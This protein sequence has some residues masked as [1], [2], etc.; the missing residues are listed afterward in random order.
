MA[1]VRI[2]NFSAGLWD[3]GG[4]E[5]SPTDS[6]GNPISLRIAEGMNAVKTTTLRS[7]GGS[8]LIRAATNVH[9]LVRFGGMRYAGVGT[10]FINVDTGAVL[11]TG[12]SGNRLNFSKM[13]AQ[14]GG[15]DYL[16]VADGSMLFKV[17]WMFPTLPMT[18]FAGFGPKN[19]PLTWPAAL[20]LNLA[21][22]GSAVWWG[23]HYLHWL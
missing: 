5:Y 15:P 22:P 18:P 9:S 4:R 16:F 20:V 10:T 14:L 23:L 12:L 2:R 3:T 8:T 11:K 1:R 21:L 19:Y 17:A 13:P 7:R 6:G